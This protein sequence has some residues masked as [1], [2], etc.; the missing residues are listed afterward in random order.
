MSAYKN[1]NTSEMKT[2][3]Q[4]YLASPRSTAQIVQRSI[5]DES[6]A[7]SKIRM[8]GHPSYYCQLITGSLRSVQ[9]AAILLGFDK[10]VWGSRLLRLRV[11]SILNPH[12]TVETIHW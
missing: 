1:I 9:C 5:S 11:A 2:L 10:R 7:I 12:R 8:L 6:T 4:T 3:R